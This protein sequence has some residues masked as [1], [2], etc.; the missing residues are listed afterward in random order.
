MKLNT[1]IVLGMAISMLPLAIASSISLVSHGPTTL[2]N[3]SGLAL[4]AIAGVVLTLWLM[5]SAT[6]SSELMQAIHAIGQGDL[7]QRLPENVS[8]DWQPL[9]VAVNNSLTT[10][11][12][13]TAELGGQVKMINQTAERIHHALQACTERADE[14]LNLS[15][16]A[17]TEL[18]EL[19]QAIGRIDEHAANAVE[20]A[21]NC[22]GNT[23]EGNES[24]SRLMGG[25]DE[26]E[27]SVGL[28]AQ[29]VEAFM[30]SMQT[31]TSMTSQVKDIADQTNLLALNA[32]IEAARAGEQGRGFAVVADEVRKLAEKS[33][34]AAREIDQVTQN[35]GQHSGK[36][37]ETIRVGRTQLTENMESLEK[38]AEA[39][40]YSRGAVITERDLIAEIAA[41]TH[42]QSQSSQAIAGHIEHMTRLASETRDRLAE[43]TQ[44]SAALNQLALKF[45]AT[46]APA[47]LK[48]Q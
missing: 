40:G 4:S 42:T 9:I 41:T 21:D 16:N 15:T 34:Q 17:S 31:I 29:S 32:A 20:Q 35:I 25:I 6:P 26:V 18:H 46:F 39:L 2:V 3:L 23:Q 47:R 45:D 33:A 13:S 8:S 22:L 24:V 27:S 1:K 30:S 5:R 36:L 37:D 28:I 44:A 11:A 43:A 38:V 14:H 10:L 12:Q 48:N 7:S 19:S